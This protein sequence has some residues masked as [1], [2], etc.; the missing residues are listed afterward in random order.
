M[1]KKYMMF[2]IGLAYFISI[3]LT[4]LS[5]FKKTNMYIKDIL[6]NSV[7]GSMSFLIMNLD[8]NK[9]TYNMIAISLIVLCYIPE[10]EVALAS[11]N[12]ESMLKI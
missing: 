4:F 7:G 10:I 8:L 9:S 2:C 12:Y 6:I 1:F 5:I 3:Y 11:S